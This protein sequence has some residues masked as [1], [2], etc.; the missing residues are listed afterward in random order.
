MKHDIVD[1]EYGTGLVLPQL[2]AFSPDAP[3]AELAA[4]YARTGAIRIGGLFTADR[5]ARI[6][7]ELDVHMTQVVPTLTRDVHYE[8]DGSVRVANELQR[9]SGYFEEVLGDPAMLRLVADVTGWKPVP[10][11]AEYFVKRPLGSVANPHQD[12]AFEHLEPHQYLHAWIA[13]DDITADMGPLRLW[14]GSNRHGVFPH[15]ERDFGGF[16]FIS[17]EVVAGFGFDVATGV[18][19]AGDAFL[20]DTAL[21]HASTRNVSDRPR[22]SLALAYRGAN[23]VH[24]NA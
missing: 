21:V 20:L 5:I 13:L 1:D 24:V 15:D 9:Y 2:R 12:S 16:K 14:L 4:E 17:R 18:A 3:V 19:A 6:R 7:A 8:A 22:P 10:F 11:Y 23:A